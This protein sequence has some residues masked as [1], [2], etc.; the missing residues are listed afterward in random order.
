MAKAVV[1]ALE[2]VQVQEKQGKSAVV[3]ACMDS[4]LF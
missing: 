3:T 1:D 4:D 2:A